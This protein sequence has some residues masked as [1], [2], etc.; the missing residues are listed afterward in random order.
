MIKNLKPTLN[1]IAIF[2]ANGRIGGEVANYIASKS[3]A[4]QLRLIIRSENHRA[5]LEEQFP[6]AEV[7]IADYY[8][9]QSLITAFDGI[10]GI[11]VVTPNRLDEECAMKNLVYAARRNVG[12]I[13]H[14]VR[15]LGDPPGMGIDRVPD[16]LR[17]AAGGT[18][19][20]HLVAK[21]V[22]STSRLPITYVNVAAYFMQN[23]SGPL[24]ALGLQKHKALVC[25]RNRRMAWIDAADI[26]KCCGA[27]LL[28][29]NHRHIGMT[30]HLDNGNDAM[31]FDKV[32]EL[33][34]EVWGEEITYDGTDESFVNLKFM[35]DM[36]T[37]VD[38]PLKKE[39]Y[40]VTYSQFEQDNELSWR[41]TDIVEFLTGEKAVKLEDW[42]RDNK[43]AIFSTDAKPRRY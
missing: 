14:I 37:P 33:M 2:G 17:N 30:Y 29:D 43:D 6:E 13:K 32:A 20:Q 28:S 31:R 8:D 40:F 9:L 24:F 1:S 26:G 11:F 15:I 5:A 16:V 19:I 42:L 25:P 12:Q 39:D 21:D 7:V 41:L 22:L 4:T 18:A 23:I 35:G 38:P 34:T 10:D 36:A 27:L 3:P